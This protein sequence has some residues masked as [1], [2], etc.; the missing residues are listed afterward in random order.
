QGGAEIAH[1]VDHHVVGGALQVRRHL[2]G[3]RRQRVADDFE[4]HRIQFRAHAAPLTETRS[5]PVLATLQRSP[6]KSTVV[7]PCSRTRAGPAIRA[8][9]PRSSRRYTGQ[10]TGRAGSPRCTFIFRRALARRF[11]ER[12][13]SSRVARLPIAATRILTI[14]TGSSG[15]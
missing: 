6:R 1:L 8:P 12:R 7:V 3:D 2:V 14:S 4:R 5:S 13:G 9:A 10:D 15:E 11:A